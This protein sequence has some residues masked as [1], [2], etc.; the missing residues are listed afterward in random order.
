[1]QKIKTGLGE[2]FLVMSANMDALEASVWDE[3]IKKQMLRQALWSRI[4]AITPGSYIVERELSSIW[5]KIVIDLDNVSVA[6]NASIPR[7]TRELNR[8]FE[9]FGYMSSTSPDGRTYLVA[10]ESN[11]SRWIE[12]GYDADDR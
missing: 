1:M 11:I 3:D 6:I 2:K 12:R 10:M 9:E 8:K 4:P 5:N 7:I